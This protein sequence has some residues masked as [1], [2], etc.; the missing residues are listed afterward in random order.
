MFLW[1]L[2]VTQSR[3]AT[4]MFGSPLLMFSCWWQHRLL[5]NIRIWEKRWHF[6]ITQ[7]VGPAF[8]IDSCGGKKM[9]A[10]C[11]GGEDWAELLVTTDWL[12]RLLSSFPGVGLLL[13]LRAGHYYKVDSPTPSNSW[14]PK[15]HLYCYVLHFVNISGRAVVILL[16]NFWRAF[17][18]WPNNW[19]C[20]LSACA[21]I[22]FSGI[23]LV[24]FLAPYSTCNA[25]IDVR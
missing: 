1:P 22:L 23:L 5:L 7:F 9:I 3:P 18:F 24:I 20:C 4:S 19:E 6:E 13:L 12:L 15:P 10:V 17:F 14:L 11:L 2:I 21:P 16:T 25:T 8:Q